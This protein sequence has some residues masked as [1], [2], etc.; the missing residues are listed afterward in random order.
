MGSDSEYI[1]KKDAEIVDRFNDNL[2]RKINKIRERHTYTHGTLMLDLIDRGVNVLALEE[3]YTTEELRL[4]ANTAREEAEY[5]NSLKVDKIRA[6][7]NIEKNIF[8]YSVTRDLKTGDADLFFDNPVLSQLSDKQLKAYDKLLNKSR[9]GDELLKL[10]GGGNTIAEY[11]DDS[12]EYILFN[13]A[14]MARKV[15]GFDS[16]DEML[17]WIVIEPTTKPRA[18]FIDRGTS[19]SANGFF[20]YLDMTKDRY[21]GWV[22]FGLPDFKPG[23]QSLES[24]LKRHFSLFGLSY[25]IEKK[26]T[27]DERLEVLKDRLVS[28]YKK[29]NKQLKP[30]IKGS[31]RKK[32]EIA[33]TELQRKMLHGERLTKLEIEVMG[34]IGRVFVIEPGREPVI[35]IVKEF[36]QRWFNIWKRGSARFNDIGVGYEG[37]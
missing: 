1:Q 22:V 9:N 15:A 32:R 26:T 18:F 8:F 10:L 16:V 3:D 2:P 27:G 13:L 24:I 34:R 36:I 21:E 11:D 19:E 31:A 28:Q 7:G 23:R 17:K 12:M 37:C 29:Y 25:S 30:L 5:L 4:F 6:T 33:V 35:N 20:S 14:D